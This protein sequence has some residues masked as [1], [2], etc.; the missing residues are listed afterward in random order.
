MIR[1]VTGVTPDHFFFNFDS[2]P[3]NNTLLIENGSISFNITCLIIHLN[4]VYRK[5]TAATHSVRGV[6]KKLFLQAFNI[7]VKNWGT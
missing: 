6:S 2:S 1:N 7:S 5:I 4:Y 3:T